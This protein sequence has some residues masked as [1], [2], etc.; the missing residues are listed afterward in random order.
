MSQR[1]VKPLNPKQ[2][3]FGR[4]LGIAIASGDRNFEQAYVKAGYRRNRGNAARLAGDQRVRAIAD[5]VAAEA[6]KHA[7]LHLGYLQ[8]KLLEMV[9]SNVYDVHRKVSAALRRPEG[10]MTPEEE[11]ALMSATWPMS[12]MAID[13]DGGLRIKLPDKK[14][15][16]ETLFKTLPGAMAPS[17]VAVTN[18]QGEDVPQLSLNDVARRIAYDWLSKPLESDSKDTTP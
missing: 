11:T 8:A 18:A 7:G 1:A 12:E 17:K 16:I 13:K 10:E 15:V 2:K 6:L 5:D 14:S 9:H 3:A 4:E